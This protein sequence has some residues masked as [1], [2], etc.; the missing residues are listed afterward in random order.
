M[1]PITHP[2]S[3]TTSVLYPHLDFNANT[4][5]KSWD[6][7]TKYW[8]SSEMVKQVVEHLTID[9]VNWQRISYMIVY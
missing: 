2:I 1:F 6:S 8:K 5:Q 9:N 4:F 3:K 7:G